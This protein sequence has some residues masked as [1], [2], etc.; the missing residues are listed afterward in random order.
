MYP[1]P[2]ANAANTGC[3]S[4]LIDSAKAQRQRF[5]RRQIKVRTLDVFLSDEV[6]RPRSVVRQQSSWVLSAAGVGALRDESAG[7]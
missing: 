2:G 4:A 3:G 5:A 1:R 7:A 6:T